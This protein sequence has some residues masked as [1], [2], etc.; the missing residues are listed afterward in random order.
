MT[1]KLGL[2]K[3]RSYRSVVVQ[4]FEWFQLTMW[5]RAWGS[6]LMYGKEKD[7]LRQ[8]QELLCLHQQTAHCENLAKLAKRKNL[9]VIC[10][11]SRNWEFWNL[12]KLAFAKPCESCETNVKLRKTHLWNLAR[13]VFAKLVK[14]NL[15]NL[16]K[17]CETL[18]AKIAKVAKTE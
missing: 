18:I 15:Q 7:V 11:F 9:F 4:E 8:I 10:K 5:I 2:S 6:W 14:H 17:H 16:A 13:L 1:R 3:L 12:A